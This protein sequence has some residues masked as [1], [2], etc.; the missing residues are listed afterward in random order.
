MSRDRTRTSERS[1]RP[2]DREPATDFDVGL[3]EDVA[4]DDGRTR[5]RRGLGGRV[6]AR[7]TALFAPRRFLLALGLSAVGLFAAGA[8][9]PLPG[10]GLLGVF[11]ATFLFGLLA[12]ERRYAEAAAAGAVTVG[13]SFLLDYAV[14]AFLGSIGPSLA[15][16]GAALGA[17]VAVAG[18]Y[19]GRDLRHGLTRDVP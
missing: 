19:F 9:V 10:S 5:E 12:E 11:L 3:D 16:V 15:L 14:V 6:A 8:V 17:V 4:A 7:A 13:A 1:G 18:T 2:A